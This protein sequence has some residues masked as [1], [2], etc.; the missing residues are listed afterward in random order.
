MS[1][2]RLAR[3]APR[4]LA[5]Q[6]SRQLPKY[7]ALSKNNLRSARLS[8]TTVCTLLV[9][10]HASTATAI[11]PP[12]PIPIPTEIITPPI[13]P[14][15]GAGDITPVLEDIR[16]MLDSQIGGD[17]VWS[18]RLRD[19]LDDLTAERR[20]R[21]AVIGD[22][23]A[24]PKDVV[25]ALLQDPLADTDESRAALL[26]RHE[27]ANIEVFQ[28]GH[29]PLPQREA[30]A[31]SLNA[32]WLQATGYDVVEVNIKTA[33]DTISTL[34]S[35]DSLLLVL[36][37]I[38]LID[39][40]QL[41]AILPLVLSR[42][43]VHF[44][45]NGHLPPHTS[46][47]AIES[48]LRDQLSRIKVDPIDDVTFNPA[49]IPISFVKA[50]KALDALDALAAGLGDNGPSTSTSKTKAFE[51]FQR[52]F[53]ESHIGPL[54]SSLLSSLQSFPEPQLS[55]ARQNAALALSH[56]EKVISH[57]RDIVK[58]AQHTVSEL[59]RG[60]SQGASKAKHLSVASRGIE[61]G[62]VE[63]SVEYDMDRVKSGLEEKF[64]GRL[65]WLGLIGRTRVDDIQFELS[66]YLS[67]QFGKDLE[68]QIIF[69]TGQLSNLQ[70]HLDHKS[71][72]TIRRLSHPTHTPSTTHPFTSP[73]LLN[74]LSTLSLS[75]PPLSP[76][77]LLTPISTRRDQLLNQSI[78]RL[79]SSAQRALL[80]TYA[81]SLLG[82]SL[83]WIS[84]VP[85][86]SLNSGATAAGLGILSI[87]ASLALGQRLWGKAQKKF[88]RDW[89]RITHMMKGDLETRFDAAL[90]TQV[91]AK[92]LAAA[93]G[94]EKLIEKREK[95]L[96][97]LQDTV[98][99]LSKRI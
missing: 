75:I 8:H 52:Q 84:Y 39:T 48:K 7:G 71:D 13:K 72:H 21:I 77:S 37:P 33:E 28:I 70:L 91:L 86:I 3:S 26:S 18:R 49:N 64:L 76:T 29:G 56:I 65:S 14:V 59:R 96:D 98:N 68:R 54:Q 78:P 22:D 31:L 2:A 92:P 19:T 60:A 79:H 81:T 55:T 27:G 46:Q 9:K 94:L 50:E 20:G 66:S 38:R 62:L 53:L 61:G 87:V 16:N 5:R 34:L 45:I 93:D 4:C 10:R 88:W 15:P 83:S 36:D 90:Q 25:S 17:D 85:P 6:P 73:L 41:S 51:I 97:E 47:S 74:H 12:E 58:D 40:P 63:G 35:T 42:G 11:K 95:R 80:T 44:V 30:E 43:S 69:E 67:N 24:G 32:S 99:S 89:K 23:L 1:L 82:V 57:D